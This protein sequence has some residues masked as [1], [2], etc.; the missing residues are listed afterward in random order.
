MYRKW[1][2]NSGHASFSNQGRPRWGQG[3][4]EGGYFMEKYYGCSNRRSNI[5]DSYRIL[6]NTLVFLPVSFNSFQ[7]YN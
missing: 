6:S 7:S 2:G 5:K 4:N 1:G 3:F